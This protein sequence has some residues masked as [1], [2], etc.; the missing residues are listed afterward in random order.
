M[1]TSHQLTATKP[2]MMK[3]IERRDDGA[4]VIEVPILPAGKIDTSL[5]S[6]GKGKVTISK[7]DLNVIV[8]NANMWP[9]PLPVH[10]GEHRKFSE[11]GGP[12]PA[13]ILKLMVRGEVLWARIYLIGPA[14]FEVLAGAWGGFSVDLVK[15]PRMPTVS[16]KGWVVTGG[17][18]TNRPATDI[19]F[20]PP[21]LPDVTE[22]A[23]AISLSISVSTDE[24]EEPV[25]ETKMSEKTSEKTPTSAEV[26]ALEMQLA[27]VKKEVD[28]FRTI[29]HQSDERNSA[30]IKQVNEGETK[31]ASLRTELS[32]ANTKVSSLDAQ[33][34]EA[35]ARITALS[36]EREQL[37]RDRASLESDLAKQKTSQIALD[38]TQTAKEAISEGVAPALFEGYDKDPAGWMRERFIS[39]DAFRSFVKTLPRDEKKALKAAAHRSGYEPDK[40]NADADKSRKKTTDLSDEEQAAFDNLN[41]SSDLSTVDDP[42]V[43]LDVIKATK[44]KDS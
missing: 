16:F 37:H 34:K 20:M 9:G 36:D 28:S 10:F 18:F 12:M 19:H 14:A 22:V 27:S 26:T 32:T 44:K 1:K 7:D 8:A 25:G 23:A 41:L 24:V 11:T 15:D 33:L 35:N 5:A 4:A 17:I 30:L 3:L 6:K 42:N 29:A 38:V 13:R 43:A 2:V 21:E 40:V 31:M 39:L